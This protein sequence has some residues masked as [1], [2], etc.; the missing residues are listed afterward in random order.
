MHAF[1][2]LQSTVGGQAARKTT[3]DLDFDDLVDFVS[4]GV[5]DWLC[6]FVLPFA[7]VWDF[8]EDFVL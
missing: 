4:P 3:S 7:C 5:P 2:T 8:P 1:G 6:D